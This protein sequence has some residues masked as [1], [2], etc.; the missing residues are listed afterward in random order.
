MVFWWFFILYIRSA[1]LAFGRLS[2][3]VDLLICK[4]VH[5]VPWVYLVV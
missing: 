1:I 2:C 4:Y 5:H 3:W